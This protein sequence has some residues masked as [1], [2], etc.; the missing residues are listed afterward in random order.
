MEQIKLTPHQEEKF[1]LIMK[2]IKA[3]ISF[4][5]DTHDLENRILSLTGP[6][7]T[8][9]SFLTAK[10]IYEVYKLKE[11]NKTLKAK[12]FDLQNKS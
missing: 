1:E 5:K 3:N 2:Q 11:E 4:S 8:G 9:K 10:I 7:G 12:L 6:A